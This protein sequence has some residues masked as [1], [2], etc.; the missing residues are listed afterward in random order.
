MMADIK[1]VAAGKCRIPSADRSS[2]SALRTLITILRIAT[3]APAFSSRIARSWNRDRTRGGTGDTGRE[4]R[5]KTRHKNRPGV[6]TR[7]C[8]KKQ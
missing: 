2:A 3:E 5:V 4:R 7:F 1:K 6:K 8:K